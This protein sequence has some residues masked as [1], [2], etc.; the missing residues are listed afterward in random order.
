V[1]IFHSA[2]ATRIHVNL[3]TNF[4]ASWVC[5][6]QG[7]DWFWNRVDGLEA[8]VERLTGEFFEICEI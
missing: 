6:F 1:D 4:S 8:I 2:C 5:P 3:E 7:G